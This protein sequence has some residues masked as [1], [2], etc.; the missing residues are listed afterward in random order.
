M[1][2]YEELAPEREEVA[3][4]MRRLYRQGLTTCSGGNL[5]RRVDGER[6]LI[7]PSSLDKGEIAADRIGLFAIDGEN[8]TPHL[9]GSIETDM[10][11]GVL[12]NRPDIDSVVHAHPVT[13]TSFAAMEMRIRCDLTAEAYAVIGE[14]AYIGYRIMGSVQLAELVAEGMKRTNVGVMKNHGVITVG[15]S[16]LQAFDRIEVLENA[17]RM[18]WITHSLG[19][20]SPLSGEQRR[21]IESGFWQT[22][23]PPKAD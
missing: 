19:S 8:L 12:R 18:T 6:A 2:S 17:A 10:H 7:T 21:E 11:L 16:M 9:K 4:W 1:K 14:V 3:Y 13:A 5:S 23:H 22:I 20:C 15:K